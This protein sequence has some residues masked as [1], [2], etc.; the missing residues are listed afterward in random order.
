MSDLN[1]LL[2]RLRQQGLRIELTVEG[3]PETLPPGIDLAAYRIVQDALASALEHAGP[4]LAHVTVRYGR[5][6]LDL[7]IADDRTRAHA[8]GNGLVALRERVAIYGG[9]LEASG[10]TGGGYAVR[11][12]LPLRAVR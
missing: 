9:E 7:E 3:G 6:A 5:D 2:E 4:V 10:R 1:G 11:A 8:G 12:H